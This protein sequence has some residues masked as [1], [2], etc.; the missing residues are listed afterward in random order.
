MLE[1]K[2]QWRG[3]S[4]IYVPPHFTSQTCP[5]CNNKSKDNRKTQADFKCV[6]CGYK[7]NADIVG[8]LNILARGHR[9]LACGETV[10]ADSV[11]QELKAA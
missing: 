6:C 1:Y 4:V 2:Q 11:K 9:V 5:S 3:G 10:L 7:N 8:A